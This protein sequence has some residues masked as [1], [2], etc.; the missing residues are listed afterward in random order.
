MG[1]S[2]FPVLH[3]QR[4]THLCM[5]L[6]GVAACCVLRILVRTG[7]LASS[8]MA[9]AQRSFDVGAASCVATDVN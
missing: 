2:N 8:C 4:G 3:A 5:E 6:V 1:A 9:R 7:H